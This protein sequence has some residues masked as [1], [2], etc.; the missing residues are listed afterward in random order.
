MQV[1][2]TWKAALANAATVAVSLV[3]ACVV[4]ALLMFRFVIPYISPTLRAYLADLP[5]VVGQTSKRDYLPHDYIAILGDSYAEGIGDWLIDAEARG[6]SQFHSA[7]VLHELTGKDVITLGRWG[8]GSAEAMVLKPS[9]VY[10][11]PPCILFPRVEKPKRILV[12]FYEGNDV[13]DN[14]NWVELRVPEA[15]SGDSL[16]QIDGYLH[17]RYGVVEW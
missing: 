5:V 6:T 15:L 9:R 16:R 1:R 3:L 11:H 13:I 12:Y 2:S 8:Y 4:A 10:F 7:H 17:D 14:N